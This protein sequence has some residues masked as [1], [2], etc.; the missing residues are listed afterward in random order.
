M[1]AVTRIA[2][3]LLAMTLTPVAG[4][5]KDGLLD[6]GWSFTR[7]EDGRNAAHPLANAEWETVSLPHTTRLE[8]RIVNDQWQG[9]AFYRRDIEA[10]QDWQGKVVLLRF[11]AAMNVAEVWLNGTQIGRHLGGYLPFTLDL[12]PHLRLGQSNRLLV[13]LDN[14]DN[15]ITGPKPLKQLDFNSYGG[16]YREVRLLVKPAVHLTDEMLADREAGGGLF[17]T[18]PQADAQAATVAIAADIRNIAPTA[19]IATVRHE[20]FDG[21]RKVGEAVETLPLEAG[22][23]RRSAVTIGV[24]NPALW[25]P[26]HPNLHRLVTHVSADGE[27]ERVE[28]RIGIRRL[29]IAK[30]GLHINGE[31][32]FLRGVNRHQEYPY[33]GYALSPLADYRDAKRIKESGFDYVRLSHYPHSP[34]FMR[35]ADEL[36][37]VVMDA[38]PGWQYINPD[39]AFRAQVLKT[40]RDM[41]RRDRNHPSVI[42]WECSLNETQMPLDLVRDFHAIVK[43]EYPG[44]QS[45]SAGW[46]DDGYDIYLQARQHRLKHYTP[47]SRPYFVSEYGDWEYYAQNAG[48]HQHGWADLKPA[49]RSSRQSLA[50]GEARLLQQ[51]TNGAEAH[52]DNLGTPALADS[53][54]VMYDYNRG[55]AEDLELS[56]LMSL[57]RLPKF[58]YW[59]F[60]SQRDAAETSPRYESGPMVHIASHWLP[61]S[62]PQVRVFTNADSVELFLNGRSL[63]VAKPD[64]AGRL[65]HPPVTFDTGGFTPG[66]LLAVAFIDGR[67]VARHSV[68]TPGAPA[69]LAV[70][71]DD[72]GVPPVADDLIFV[73]ATVTD[74]AGNKVPDA[75]HNVTFQAEGDYALVGPG[76]MAA[77][78]GIASMLVRVLKANPQGTITATAEGL[79]TGRL[80]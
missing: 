52:T 37:L 44:E 2:A 8:P 34:A 16:L 71:L 39:L 31:K 5:A 25:S 62:A 76:V 19:R 9:I 69:A 12:T 38:I 61:G 50:D 45:W 21:E 72:A 59:F 74:A 35:A 24:E 32:L 75:G 63:G 56:G 15:P 43:A 28:T 27:E 70:T 60:R 41:I 23:T 17:I 1:K 11:E 18:Y 33:V 14:R 67:E 7:V 57:E 26:R 47:S 53:Y 54:W 65:A 13:R 6:K 36:G 55:Y 46:Q 51:A 73:R 22:A 29:S 49:E 78:G 80:P 20:L 66:T 79:S 40:C 30:D 68:T 10:P 48:F 4:L 58:L 64:A 42:A 3:F 77:E